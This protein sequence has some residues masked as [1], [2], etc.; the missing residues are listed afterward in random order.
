MKKSIFALIIAAFAIMLVAGCGGT[1]Q[2]GADKTA[3]KPIKIG[4]TAGPHADVVQA[5]AKE[6]K[7][8][9]LDVQV[10]EFSD[11]V[12]PDKALAEGDLDLNSY[13]HAPFLQNFDK[14]NNSKLVPIGNTI[15]MRMGIYSDKYHDVKALPDKAVI[16]IPNDPT[17][18]GRGLVLLEKAGLL[19]LKPGVGFKATVKDVVDNPKHF[20]FRELEA[21]QLP[22][23]LADVD[24][25]VITMNYVMSAG[26]DVKKQGMFWEKND[27]PL[28]V[29]VLA[30]REKDKDNPT[31]KKIAAIFHSEAVK[32]YIA[33]KFKGTIVPAE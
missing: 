31:Y 3:S 21:A 23:S 4:A 5:V 16:A 30:A 2:K 14:Q 28:A 11:Y 8:Q 32:Q 33:D 18:G 20:E 19:K 6:A 10:I 25:A 13:Q 22:R 7:K 29:M 17:N 12:T 15:L 1:T 26:L 27:E 24:A 9:G